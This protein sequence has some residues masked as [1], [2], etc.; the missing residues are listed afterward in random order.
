M[1]PRFLIQTINGVIRHDFCFTLIESIRYQNWLRNDDELD[2]RLSDTIDESRRIP[3]GSVEFVS[4]YLLHYHNLSPKPINVP[5]SLM[6]KEWS[7]RNIINGTEKDIN[8]KCFI[9]S[10]DKIKGFADICDC[11]PA[12]NYQISDVVDIDSE[13]RAF[14]YKNKLVGLQC[15]SGQFYTFPNVDRI[16]SMISAFHSAPIAYTLDVFVNP[17]G[18][19]VLEVH[20]FFSCGLYGFAEHKILPFMFSQWF[21]EYTSKKTI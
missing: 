21:F 7:G 5:T 16:N 13:W 9:K 18:T 4:E 8:G 15:Y 10:L 3:V 12:G 20:D 14:V 6:D 2:Y 1:E 11:A 17:K 19:F